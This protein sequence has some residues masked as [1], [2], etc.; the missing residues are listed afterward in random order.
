MHVNDGRNGSFSASP[1]LKANNH[2][3]GSYQSKWSYRKGWY[4]II[5]RKIIPQKKQKG[6][7]L[8]MIENVLYNDDCSAHNRSDSDSYRDY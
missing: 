1:R 2:L 8:I 4:K 5:K 3:I 6:K 7:I